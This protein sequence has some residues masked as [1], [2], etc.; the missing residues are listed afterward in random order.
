MH[1]GSKGPSRVDVNRGKGGGGPKDDVFPK[2][3]L[4]LQNPHFTEKGPF[5][6]ERSFYKIGRFRKI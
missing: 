3:D 1:S 4:F 6:K 5:C 2:M